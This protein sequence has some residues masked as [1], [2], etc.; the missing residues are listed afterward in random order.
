MKN[1]FK[2]IVLLCLSVSFLFPVLP[3]VIT[4]EEQSCTTITYYSKKE[5]VQHYNLIDGEWDAGMN[6]FLTSTDIVVHANT[7]GTFANPWMASSKS[8]KGVESVNIDATTNPNDQNFFTIS[9]GKPIQI[10][11]I[12]YQISAL[13]SSSGKQL[14]YK[15][16]LNAGMKWVDGVS[17]VTGGE[18][19]YES[20]LPTKT[21]L[22][23]QGK[24]ISSITLWFDEYSQDNVYSFNYF[25]VNSYRVNEH[26]EWTTELIE[27]AETKQVQICNGTGNFT[28]DGNGKWEK[29]SSTIFSPSVNIVSNYVPIVS[30]QSVS[31][32]ACRGNYI[33]AY[34]QPNCI[35]G[36]DTPSQSIRGWSEKGSRPWST[37]FSYGS[38]GT[39][40]PMIQTSTTTGVQYEASPV[41]WSQNKETNWMSGVSS[42]DA[43]WCNHTTGSSRTPCY[44]HTGHSSNSRLNSYDVNVKTYKNVVD[45]SLRTIKTVKYSLVNEDTKKEIFLFEGKDELKTFDFNESG[46]WRIKAVVTDMAGLSGSKSSNI[47]Y[48]DN[49]IPFV[50]F[51]PSSDTTVENEGINVQFSIKDNHSGIERWRYAISKDGGVTWDDYSEFLA[52]P[53]YKLYFLDAGSYQVKVHVIDKAGNESTTFSP[54]YTIERGRASLG[55]MVTSAYEI[56]QPN[57]LTLKIDNI[58]TQADSEVTLHITCDGN[59]VFNE[60]I[61]LH[62]NQ[63]MNV[64]CTPTNPTATLVATLESRNGVVIDNHTLTLVANAKTYESKES[65]SGG[66]EFKAP[67]VFMVE[68]GAKQVNYSEE[69][70][71]TLRQ[72]KETYFAGEGINT[73]VESTYYN[74][75]A[76]IQNWECVGSGTLTTGSASATFHDSAK[77]VDKVFGKNGEFIVPLEMINN[78]FV[79]PSFVASKKEGKIYLDSNDVPTHDTPLDAGRKWYTN[80]RAV[81]KVYDYQISGL[82]TAINKFQWI[83]ESSYQIKATIKNQYRIRF[84]D[85]NNPF[86]NTYS[87]TW[88]KDKAWFAL[89]E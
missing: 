30:S 3:Q 18:L 45:P 34:S 42:G 9:F 52:N 21:K 60:S 10:D 82:D 89:F 37:Y 8:F 75:C 69:L 51:N 55:K 27:G 47:F 61:N 48:I 88:S 77:E 39:S 14:N 72:D 40:F 74:E 29:K 57:I 87:T 15:L 76:T 13:N 83:F 66:L 36:M 81:E 79:F 43:G 25:Q 31:Y 73:R 24:T 32:D 54:L 50:T 59:E 65:S 17:T 5:W 38:G 46:Q 41:Y 70:K 4:A 33:S 6:N 19:F 86:P 58:D 44:K 26:V 16:Y 22:N 1:L 64:T 49:Q 67:T 7:F 63:T 28:P 53:T 80:Q 62:Q 71:L 23:L 68:Q 78:E 56:N 85:P 12:E 20:S 2:S 84:V 35:K 11:E